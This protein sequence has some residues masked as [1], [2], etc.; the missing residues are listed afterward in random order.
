MTFRGFWGLG[1][2]G[3]GIL[4]CRGFGCRCWAGRW[5]QGLDSCSRER[6]KSSGWMVEDWLRDSKV[7]GG[8]RV[9]GLSPEL[10]KLWDVRV[11]DFGDVLFVFFF[12]L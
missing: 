7:T 11:Q 10:P 9:T 1:L 5:A 3:R 12:G 6:E 8:F 4:G 2:H